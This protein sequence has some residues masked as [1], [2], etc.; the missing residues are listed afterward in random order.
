MNFPSEQATSREQIVARQRAYL[1]SLDAQTASK[2]HSSAQEAL[3]DGRFV[4]NL[5]STPDDSVLLAPLPPVNDVSPRRRR[6]RAANKPQ[7]ALDNKRRYGKGYESGV[8][9]ALTGGGYGNDRDDRVEAEMD[10]MSIDFGKPL[11]LG[12]NQFGDN[13]F[14]SKQSRNHPD[15]AGN[16]DYSN[17]TTL[18]NSVI[19]QHLNKFSSAL[20]R[21]ESTVSHLVSSLNTT[22]EQISSQNSMLMNQHKRD[23]DALG[24]MRD[25]LKTLEAE[26]ID[27]RSLRVD[28]ERSR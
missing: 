10:S 14:G 13:Q 12:N 17:T 15:Q 5:P 22:K 28:M 26:L 2:A 16:L 20:A 27:M 8:G 23:S 24:V 7:N 25:R 9:E 11:M 4:R 19:S 3:N 1:A 21:S 18:L 6:N